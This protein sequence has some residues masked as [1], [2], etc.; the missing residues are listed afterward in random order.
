MTESDN[1]LTSEEIEQYRA[2]SL[3][4]DEK[5]RRAAFADEAKR[6][7]YAHYP[8]KGYYVDN[9]GNRRDEDGRKC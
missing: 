2:E 1:D 7:G 3:I 6:L 8:E 5:M 9:E 4:V